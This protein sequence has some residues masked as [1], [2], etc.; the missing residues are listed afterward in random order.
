MRYCGWLLGLLP[1]VALPVQAADLAK[2]DRM[3]RQEPKYEGKPRY[4]LLVFG[5]EAKTRVWLVRAGDRL[6]VDK[7]GNGD[8]TEPG[9]AVQMGRPSP[10]HFPTQSY[11]SPEVEIVINGHR[12]GKVQLTERRLHPEFKPTDEYEKETWQRFQRVEGGIETIIRVSELA[13]LPRGEGKPFAARIEQA[14]GWDSAGQL[15]FAARPKDAPIVHFDGPLTLHIAT[16]IESPRLEKSDKPFDFQISVGT[17]G[18]GK[19][20]FADLNYS[21][22]GPKGDVTDVTPQDVYP[23]AEVEFPAKAPNGEPVR[24]HWTLKQRC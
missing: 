16:G 14:A 17:Q 24:A 15:A 10:R 6:Y 23:A 11:E 12:W 9:E 1:L 21:F 18:I 3:I 22:T 5:P 20:T 2:M 7:N 8:L 4:C 19:G 13:P